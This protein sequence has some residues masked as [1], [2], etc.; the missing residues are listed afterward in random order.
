MDGLLILDKPRGCTSH[1]VVLD[2]RRLLGFGRVGHGGTLDPDATGV[3]LIALGQAARFFPY[4]SGQDKVYEGT[5]R[6]G[7]TTDTYDASGRPTST[8]K[9]FALPSADEVRAAMKNLEGET[10]QVPPPYSAKKIAGR[11]AYRLAR[12]HKEVS[13]EPVRVTVQAF[14][15]KGYAPPLAAFEARCSSGTYVRSLAHDLGKALGCGAHLQELR[16]TVSG[17]YTLALAV[18][19]DAVERAAA[20]GRIRELVIPLEE[21]L[22]E[23]PA[24]VLVPE[25]IGRARN[26]SPLLPEHVA[27]PLRDALLSGRDRLYRI[28]EPSGRLLG[29]ARPSPGGDALKPF[30]VVR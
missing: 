26:G 29:L 1:D 19:L 21:L 14:A 4:L 30:L 3:L 25:A 6:L 5:I 27:G 15:L 12:A 7:F 8:D 23:T 10:L 17:P 28:F 22:P 18:T 20:A 24:V 11:P 2:V 9:A 16:R 13:L